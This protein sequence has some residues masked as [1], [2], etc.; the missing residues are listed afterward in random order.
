[1]V[2]A[3]RLFAAR[4]V[5]LVGFALIALGTI[6]WISGAISVQWMADNVPD[7]QHKEYKHL[8]IFGFQDQVCDCVNWKRE[9]KH[10]VSITCP[11]MITNGRNASSSFWNGTYAYGKGINVASRYALITSALAVLELGLLRSAPAVVLP[12]LQ[13]ALW[14]AQLGAISYTVYLAFTVMHALDMFWR[15]GCTESSNFVDYGVV[16][17]RT[18]YHIHVSVSITF[19]LSVL[20][21]TMVLFWRRSGAPLFLL[22][23]TWQMAMGCWLSESNHFFEHDT[24]VIPEVAGHVGKHFGLWLACDCKP[25]PC[26]A[27]Q[28]FIKFTEEVIRVSAVLCAVSL[29]LIGFELYRN[30]DS[31]VR[32]PAIL[33]SSAAFSLMAVTMCLFVA[34]FER[35]PMSGA[36][37]RDADSFADK[38]KLGWGWY[39]MA[40]NGCVDFGLGIL[41][42]AVGAS[43]ADRRRTIS[44]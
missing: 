2:T 41:L 15:W 18:Y 22:A 43:I 26:V 39:L 16:P 29:V 40:Y 6:Y 17:G 27:A 7:S 33:T 9:P 30:V 34:L 25:H 28:P 4:T 10:D 35:A 13:K 5:Q 14:A 24:G 32:R 44:I 36:D 11:D 42:L 12:I 38:A 31:I 20:G 21:A 8:Q 3:P 19:V 1:M 23:A 37:C